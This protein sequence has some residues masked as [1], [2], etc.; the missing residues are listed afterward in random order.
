MAHAV[1]GNEGYVT[2]ADRIVI[3]VP[4]TQSGRAADADAAKC[5]AM[6][7]EEMKQVQ[8]VV[9]DVST[10]INI[11]V[12]PESA[13]PLCCRHWR[14]MIGLGLSAAA[15]ATG[16]AIVI[17][18]LG[19]NSTRSKLDDAVDEATVSGELLLSVEDAA[20]FISHASS[21]LAIAT[22]IAGLH[23]AITVDSVKIDSLRI[24][25]PR[26]LRAGH[27]RRIASLPVLA[28][29]SVTVASEG[30]ELA[31]GLNAMSTSELSANLV[32]AM[33]QSSLHF[34]VSVVHMKAWPSKSK[35]HGKEHVHHEYDGKDAWAK[36]HEKQEHDQ[37]GNN[38][39]TIKHDEGFWNKNDTHGNGL[40][41]GE[42]HRENHTWHKEGKG[43]MGAWDRKDGH[44]NR[45]SMD[46]HGGWHKDGK[47]GKGGG[48][49]TWLKEGKGEMEAWAKKG[50][51]GNSS[52]MEDR[53]GWDENSS[54]TSKPQGSNGKGGKGGKGGIGGKGQNADGD[55]HGDDED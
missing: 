46:K 13:K 3:G 27:G 42:H 25:D 37:E 31:D 47:H 19:G 8:G 53:W 1:T 23:E 45:S 11:A 22:A 54:A 18:L 40:W 9:L 36:H 16:I 30:D 52:L 50:G 35:K 38:G 21:K 33:H 5:K 39:E 12:A 20:D 51:H 2:Q 44:G 49:K 4:T 6:D 41:H 17:A 14:L 55:D 43:E 29:Y 24:A 48:N 32:D 28:D 34:Q 15:L 26:V 7:G 10:S